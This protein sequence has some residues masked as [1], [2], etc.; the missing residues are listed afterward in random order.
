MPTDL[1]KGAGGIFQSRGVTVHKVEAALEKVRGGRKVDSP[2]PEATY[3]AL[4]KYA[5]DLTK[6]AEAGKLDPV[7]GRDAEIRRVTQVLSRRRKNNPVLIGDPGVGKT[8][9]AEGLAV[10]IASPTDA[11]LESPTKTPNGGRHDRGR[12]LEAGSTFSIRA[13]L[14]DTSLFQARALCNA[15]A[16]LNSFQRF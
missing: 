9:I 8:A 4:D 12:F 7:I 16:P 14:L 15:P 3:E 13:V 6:E 2:N 10:R 1:A 11:R 5:R